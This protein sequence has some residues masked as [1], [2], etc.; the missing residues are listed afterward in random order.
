MKNTL[1]IILG[2]GALISAAAA[3]LAAVE[4]STKKF[5]DTNTCPATF[6]ANNI[7]IPCDK[8]WE[9]DKLHHAVLPHRDEPYTQDI[10]WE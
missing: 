10:F 2:A 8:P 5:R 6:T 3:L 9:H 4:V 7:H 1:R